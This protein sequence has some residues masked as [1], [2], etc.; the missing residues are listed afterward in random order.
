MKN[1]AAIIIGG[2][3][4]PMAG[5][6]L[7]ARI[8]EQTRTDGTD[9]SH[10]HLVH[11]SCSPAI[12][13]RTE[14][15]V[16]LR[17]GQNVADTKA[18]PA[19]AMAEVFERASRVPFAGGFVGGI[20]CNTFH[21]PPIFEHFQKILREKQTPVR[22]V[23]MLEATMQLI[24]ARLGKAPGEK[25]DGEKIGVLATLGTLSSGVYDSLLKASGYTPLY[26]DA[27]DNNAVHN[28]IYN[29]EWGIK[30]ISPVSGKAVELVRAMAEKC[31][32]AGVS[33]TIL[34]CTELP[35]AVPEADHAKMPLIDPVLA[36]ARAL[37]HEAAPEKLKPLL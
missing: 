36:L 26:L 7:H 16:A 27:E 18:S 34:G 11:Y 37:V 21:A 23:H 22:V 28:A 24:G 9:Q 33:A 20:P 35:L 1:E 6:A 4:G 14:Y 31:K 2:G 15:L 32:K 12:T 8:I 29:R 17:S 19:L 3:V 30:A 10:L 13:D 5:V 25:G